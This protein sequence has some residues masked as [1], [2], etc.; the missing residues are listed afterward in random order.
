M[1]CGVE[2]DW[3]GDHPIDGHAYVVC[4]LRNFRPSEIALLI[5]YRWCLTNRAEACMAPPPV[6]CSHLGDSGG[7][8]GGWRDC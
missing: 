1:K 7:E 6:A 2:L 5:H 8:P 4:L 3:R